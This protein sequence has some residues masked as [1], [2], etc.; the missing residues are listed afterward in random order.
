M[1]LRWYLDFLL[2]IFDE[3]R[4]RLSERD[5]RRRHRLYTRTPNLTGWANV[6]FLGDSRTSSMTTIWKYEFYIDSTLKASL[7]SNSIV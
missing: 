6:V 5:I 4:P 3:R 1:I 2:L 7:R